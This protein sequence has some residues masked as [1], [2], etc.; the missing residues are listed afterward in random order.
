MLFHEH[1]Y[2]KKQTLSNR[3]RRHSDWTDPN[4]RIQ[5]RTWRIRCVE[6]RFCRQHQRC[7]RNRRHNTGTVSCSPILLVI[8]PRRCSLT[9]VYA[10][11]GGV[12]VEP[13][14]HL[15]AAFSPATGETALLNDECA[16]ILELLEELTCATT[17]VI[18]GHL[19]SD[20]GMPM[21]SL[22]ELVENSW[23]RLLEAGLVR[24][25]S[26]HPITYSQ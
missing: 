24:E 3:C 23:P 8:L 25:T 13:I 15:W 18:C 10:R 12:L 7:G 17:D 11:L 4:N 20:S 9:P 5:D 26:A 6:N 22:T 2:R 16:S 14:G 21:Q 19:S 1:H